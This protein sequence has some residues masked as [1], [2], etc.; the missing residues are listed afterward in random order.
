MQ[1]ASRTAGD[2]VSDLDHGADVDGLGSPLEALDLR[3]MMS[4]ISDES[5]MV[6]PL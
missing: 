5:V 6:L 3:L 2:P 1:F 4:V